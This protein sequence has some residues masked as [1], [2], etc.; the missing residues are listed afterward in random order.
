MINQDNLKIMKLP[1]VIL[2]L[3]SISVFSQKTLFT[4]TEWSDTTNEFYNNVSNTRKYE[5]T[6]FV[7]YWGD[8]VGNDPSTY[9]DANL[10]FVPRSVADTLEYSFKRYITDLKF[11]SNAPT[12]NLGKYKIIVMMMGTWN[13]TDLRLNDV[14]II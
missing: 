4:P 1:F 2:L 14:L 5:S 3:C 8:K 11:C 10:R 6:N 13:S 7:L 12:T 9:S